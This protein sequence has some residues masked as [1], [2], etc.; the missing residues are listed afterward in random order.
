MYT[1]RPGSEGKTMKKIFQKSNR[2]SE[3][4]DWTE[5]AKKKSKN[6]NKLQHLTQK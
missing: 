2:L 5:T 6:M 3:Q 4:A 1:L